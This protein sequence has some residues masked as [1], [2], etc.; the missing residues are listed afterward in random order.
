MLTNKLKISL[1]QNRKI[2]RVVKPSNKL[3]FVAVQQFDKLKFIGHFA[4]N[5]NVIRKSRYFEQPLKLAMNPNFRYKIGIGCVI[6]FFSRKSI[7]EQSRILYGNCIYSAQLRVFGRGSKFILE[8]KK[9]LVERLRFRGV[10]SMQPE[11]LNAW[12]NWCRKTHR[13]IIPTK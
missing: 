5:S 12:F 3:Q 13:C 9:L 2:V 11:I 4:K 8:F 7:G 1:C 6:V 10:N